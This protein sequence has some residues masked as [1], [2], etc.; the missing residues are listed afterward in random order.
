[1]ILQGFTFL[2]QSGS[3]PYTGMGVSYYGA[4]TE[5]VSD[6][7]AGEH[8]GNLIMITKNSPIG[9]AVLGRKQSDVI[10]VI[11]GANSINYKIEKLDNSYM[12]L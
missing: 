5:V 3:S 12:R 1:M 6:S 8:D 9:K 11:V 4:H 2:S 7:R 10:K